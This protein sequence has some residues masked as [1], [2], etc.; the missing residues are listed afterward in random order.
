MTTGCLAWPCRP[1]WTTWARAMCR[2]RVIW[3]CPIVWKWDRLLAWPISSRLS[4]LCR[5]KDNT[6]NE[7]STITTTGSVKMT[8]KRWSRRVG[9]TRRVKLNYSKIHGSSFI[10]NHI[11]SSMSFDT[12]TI[13]LKRNGTRTSAS[14]AWR[15]RSLLTVPWE[16]AIDCNF[17]YIIIYISHHYHLFLQK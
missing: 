13:R 8:P 17:I 14:C 7:R 1:Y 9:A 10:S 16:P 12:D 15:I 3:S 6:N 4:H 11:P 5:L 2:I